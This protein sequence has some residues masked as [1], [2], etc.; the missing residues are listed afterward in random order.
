MGA[1]GRQAHLGQS[2]A[3]VR[4]A[5]RLLSGLMCRREGAFANA[6]AQLVVLLQRRVTSKCVKNIFWTP[7]EC[8]VTTPIRYSWL[9]C[10]C[11]T[12]DEPLLLS[13]LPPPPPRSSTGPVP[14]GG[15]IR[16]FC[17]DAFIVDGGF[18]LACRLVHLDLW[19]ACRN[20]STPS[21]PLGA[22]RSC[23]SS[24]MP[25][26]EHEKVIGRG[27]SEVPPTTEDQLC[28]CSLGRYWMEQ[29]TWSHTR[30]LAGTGTQSS[31]RLL[32]TLPCQ[33]FLLCSTFYGCA[34]LHVNS[35]TRFFCFVLAA[36]VFATARSACTILNRICMRY[37]GLFLSRGAASMAK[38]RRVRVQQDTL[39]IRWT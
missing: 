33:T 10:T 34:S 15:G 29:R 13:L 18:L 7:I 27:T 31:R 9:F 24:Y 21:A 25:P 3:L 19:P 4:D 38:H 8:S 36:S 30:P 2:R 23:P 22:R 11:P 14:C 32:N 17:G 12:P 39:D 6:R 35:R 20:Y 5:N 37:A 1:C 16:P 26:E 28:S